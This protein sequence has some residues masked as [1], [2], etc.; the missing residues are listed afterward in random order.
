MDYVYI[1]R[2]GDNDELRYSLRSIEENMPEGR[3]WV[4]G[5]RPIWY[6]GDFIP[7]DDIG[8]KFDNIVNCIKTVSENNDISDN[9]ILMNDDFFALNPIDKLKNYHGGLLENK[10]ARYKE[11]R[12]APKY[13]RLLELTLK[14]LKENGISNPIDYDIHVPI[15]MNKTILK[16]A[17][18]LAFFPRSA[19][20]NL[21]KLEAIKITDVKIYSNGEK[22]NWHEIINNDFVSTED[23]SFISLKNN[24]LNKMFDKPSQLENPNY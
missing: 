13:I 22:I 9:F 21:A 19:Y 16:D 18:N 4:V 10:I 17:I 7:V 1:C 2:N 15:I 8:G 20:G 23:N 6:I 24:I 5:H 12:M 11:L 3:V 14:Q